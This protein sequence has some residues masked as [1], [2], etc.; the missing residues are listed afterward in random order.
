MNTDNGQIQRALNETKRRELEERFGAVHTFSDPG[1]PP[2]VEGEWLDEVLEFE[3]MAEGARTITVRAFIGNPSLKPL[4]EVPPE[5]L[6]AEVQALLDLLGE[7][8]VM[9]CFEHEVSDAETYRFLTEE[10]LALEV[11]EVRIP[12]MF[13]VFSYEDFHPDDQKEASRCAKVF[14]NSLLRGDI[15]TASCYVYEGAKED[16]SGIAESMRDAIRRF[17]GSIAVFVQTGVGITSCVV[18]GESARI[19]ADVRWTGVRREDHRLAIES[20]QAVLTMRRSPAGGWDVREARIPGGL[21]LGV[22]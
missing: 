16:G 21:V 8:Q 12:G 6:K 18:E 11:E 15:D 4:G 20:G 13:T 3:R 7:H 2:E 17:C 22:S 10:L 19:E 14:L 9:V 1:V 5:E